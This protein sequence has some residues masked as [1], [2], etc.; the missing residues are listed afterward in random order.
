M[1]LAFRLSARGK[2]PPPD[3]RRTTKKSARPAAV[4]A[5][6]SPSG[7][8]LLTEIT[9]QRATYVI[10]G[11]GRRD[12]RST[13]VEGGGRRQA[14][15]W[16]PPTTA[17]MSR[18][19]SPVIGRAFL[20]LDARRTMARKHSRTNYPA[21]HSPSNSVSLCPVPFRNLYILS[22]GYSVCA[23]RTLRVSS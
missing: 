14:A 23:T 19:R 21:P 20:V 22:R 3:E 6:L 4:L 12:T 9:V 10:N 8:V 1:F 11:G 18:A 17:V 5:L 15:R 7:G 2:K 13:P 16:K